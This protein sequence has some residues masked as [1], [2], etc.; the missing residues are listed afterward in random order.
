MQTISAAV[1]TRHLLIEPAVVRIAALAALIGA[2]LASF[3]LLALAL[4][5]A[6]WRHLWGR[7]RRQ[8]A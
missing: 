2:G 7:L 4:G 6:D 3:V 1:R 8:P 5:I